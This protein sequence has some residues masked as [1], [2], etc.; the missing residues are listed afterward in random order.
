M[1]E[2]VFRNSLEVAAEHADP[3]NPHIHVAG[4]SWA[5]GRWVDLYVSANGSGI[6]DQEQVAITAEEESSLEHASDLGLWLVRWGATTMGGD[7]SL[8]DDDGESE[9]Q[10]AGAPS[11]GST[12]K[13]HLP[14]QS[15]AGEET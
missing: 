3:G 11:G 14:Q 9:G 4:E 2:T 12:L 5:N 1:F 7:V 10:P 15:G 13:I 6:P 8:L